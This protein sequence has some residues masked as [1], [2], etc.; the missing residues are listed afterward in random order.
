MKK[1]T[2]PLIELQRQPVQKL[3]W[4]YAVP[5]IIGT[6]VAGLYDVID[7]IFIGQGFGADAIAGLALT[8]PIMILAEALAVLVGAGAASRLSIALGRG[9]RPEAEAILMNSVYLTLF[10]S[11]LYVIFSLIFLDEF[12]NLFGGDPVINPYAKA[13]LRILIPSVFISNM[14]F[15][16]NNLMRASGY[17]RKAMITLLLGGVANVIFDP[18]VIYVLHWGISAIA[19]ATFISV[20]LSAIFVLAHFFNRKLTISFYTRY[21]KINFR[22]IGSILSLGAGP[23]LINASRA[24]I[25]IFINRALNKYGGNMAIGAYGVINTFT[26][27]IMMAVFGLCQGMQPIVGYSWGARRFD[28]M[29]QAFK[30]TAIY[31]SV[32]SIAGFFIGEFLPRYI[33]E[34]FTHDEIMIRMAMHGLRI[35]LWY[36]PFVGL[37]IV[38]SNFYQAIG[39]ARESIFLTMLRQILLLIP[40]VIIFPHIWGRDGVWLSLPVSDITAALVTF[41]IL[42]RQ[43]SLFTT[44]KA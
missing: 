34:A 13:F 37:Q 31:A 21:R 18:I 4:H 3:L 7:R 12:L 11:S 40:C 41:W 39:K 16:L 24:V 1:N 27:F 38:I 44:G 35:S 28:R 30:L 25:I 6:T 26:T 19:T 17:P 8:F 10:F 20:T 33:S 43:R 22:I 36:F 32:I 9:D 29:R 42:Y 2:S 23:F 14:A 15:S 5:A